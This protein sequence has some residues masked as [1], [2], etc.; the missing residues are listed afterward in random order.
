MTVLLLLIPVTLALIGLFMGLFIFAA[1]S[2]QFEDLNTPA[3]R[4]FFEDYDKQNKE[5]DLSNESSVS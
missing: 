5:R 4:I 3:H 2:G 1:R